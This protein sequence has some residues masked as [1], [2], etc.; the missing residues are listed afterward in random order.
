MVRA[1]KCWLAFL[2]PVILPSPPSL[3]EMAC[4]LAHTRCAMAHPSEQQCLYSRNVCALFCV[5]F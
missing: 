5:I 1:L 2:L 4:R 3:D